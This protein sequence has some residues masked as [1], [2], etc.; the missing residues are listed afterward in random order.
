MA[1]VKRK[2]L[3]FEEG[4]FLAAVAGRW[5]SSALLTVPHS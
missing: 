4:F 3:S 2:S 1:S 5:L